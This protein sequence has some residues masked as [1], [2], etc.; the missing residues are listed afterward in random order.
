M[1]LGNKSFETA[2][3]STGLAGSWTTSF[4]SSVESFPDFS[5]G[6]GAQDPEEDFEDGWNNAG[7]LLTLALADATVGDFN[8]GSLQTQFES[9]ET[10]WG[11]NEDYLFEVT[12]STSAEF[13]A[14]SLTEEGFEREWLLTRVKVDP[15]TNVLTAIDD[16]LADI[17]HRL[18]DGTPIRFGTVGTYPDPL[19]ND[20]RYVRDST[21]YTFKLAATI[22]GSATDIT[23]AGS[24]TFY[25]DRI[26][27]STFVAGQ[28]TPGVFDNTT[29]TDDF[30]TGWGNDAYLTT[31]GGGDVTLGVFSA[32]GSAEVFE[33]F[34]DVV[35]TFSFTAITSSTTLTS[36]GHGLDNDMPVKLKGPGV[37][38]GFAV[39]VLYYVVNRTA[40][41]FELSLTLGGSAIAA[42]T[43][44]LAGTATVFGDPAQFW[45]DVE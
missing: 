26:P 21:T 1:A 24:G 20:V 27:L 11:A 14:T 13:G 43:D 16:A 12:L 45:N 23:T 44:S 7:F 30:E 31:L 37:P 35:G 8:S 33:S 42:T 41:T 18:G 36:A 9:F 22:G 38:G 29:D 19:D 15:V 4:V 3:A 2:G 6:S 25:V 28:V 17:V 32:T 40:D 10:Q 39:G 34:E 5:G